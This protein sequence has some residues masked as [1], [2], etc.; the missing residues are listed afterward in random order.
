[1]I[2]LKFLLLSLLF[3][4][5]GLSQFYNPNNVFQGEGYCGCEIFVFTIEDPIIP[6]QI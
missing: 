3:C 1:M 4:A 5:N 6:R 2:K